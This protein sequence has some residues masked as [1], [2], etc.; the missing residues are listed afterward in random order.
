MPE[1]DEKNLVERSQQNDPDAFNELVIRYQDRIFNTVYRITHNHATS[2]DICQESF[3]RAF[4]SIKKFKK[5]SRFSTWLHQIAVNLCFNYKRARKPMT[6]LPD[7]DLLNHHP[8]DNP[9]SNPGAALEN[10]EQS[11]IVQQALNSLEPDLRSIVVLKDVEGYS[12]EEISTVLR[13]SIGAVRGKLAKARESLKQQ[14]HK[15]I[16]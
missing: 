4:Q 16:G 12:Y 7:D 8:S 15:L 5:Q 2:L 3:L 6:G 9:T 10:D 13:Y 1:L 11:Q 14:L